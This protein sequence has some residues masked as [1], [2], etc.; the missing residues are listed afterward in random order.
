M[1]S[2]STYGPHTP[3][4]KSLEHHVAEV[5]RQ[6]IPDLFAADPRRFEHFSREQSGLLLDFSR[7]HLDARGLELLLDLAE[8]TGV[9]EWTRCMFA[10]ERINNTENRPALHIALRRSADEPLTV[11]GENIMPL[12]EAE[13]L[14]MRHLADRIAAG[15]LNGFSGEPIRAVVNIGIGGSELGAAMAI[16][17]LARFR[18][19]GL[20]VHFV[21]N[22]DSAQLD[23][24]IAT[25]DA[26]STLVIVCSKTFS[27]LETLSNAK[28]ARQW[29]TAA[30]GADAINSQLV[31][32]SA[33]A[34]A[35]E[36]F[37]IAAANRFAVW[38]WVGGRFSMWSSVGLVAA[39]VLGMH[40]FEE[41]LAGAREMDA[42]FDSAELA[43]NLPVL[44]GLIGVWNRNFLDAHSHVI[45]PY[46]QR[47]H[48]FPVYLQQL[49]MESNGKRVR[50]GGEPVECATAPATWGQPGSNAQ[51]SILQQ[52]HQGT[53][54]ASIDFLASV[55][56]AGDA[57]QLRDLLLSNCLAQAQVL[58]GGWQPEE[59]GDLRPHRHQPGNRGSTLIL[60]AEL[61]AH[62]LGR[63][64]ALYEH[65]VFVQSVIWDVNP[66]DQWSIESGKQ[67]EPTIRQSLAARAAG[68][69]KYDPIAG[70]LSQIAKWGL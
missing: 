45:L 49:E 65:K 40:C 15:E 68:A 66:F 14:R 35:M 59:S 51:H 22:I 50:R 43:D 7:Q 55:R 8:Q 5:R 21:S 37:G 52:L 53:S 3:A 36:S 60:V 69:G 31:G 29:L 61:S 18:R 56:G 26:A 47:L 44:L 6:R 9:A 41:I 33:N 2:N 17:A 32:V 10:G 23:D 24:A 19:P 30:G 25:L 38:D 46:D 12:V 11:D 67:V 62:A 63:L 20:S 48:R 58:A 28:R 4:W 1:P 64:V 54:P 13:R 57:P 70:A 16:E 34:A 42:H 39:L 27:T